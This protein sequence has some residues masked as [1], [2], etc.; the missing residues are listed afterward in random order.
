[1]ALTSTTSLERCTESQIDDIGAHSDR[2]I[3]IA[4]G[5]DIVSLSLGDA[6]EF[7][8]STC[9]TRS[10]NQRHYEARSAVCR[11]KTVT[12]RADRGF[13]PRVSI[14]LR[15]IH[16]EYSR[17]QVMSKIEKAAGNAVKR[18]AFKAAKAAEP[19]QKKAKSTK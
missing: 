11:K 3:D 18:Y 7:V 9:F 12:N 10:T 2:M 4:P 13:K 19:S 14:V 5:T 8:L 17:A 16:T 6:R 1:M 15:K